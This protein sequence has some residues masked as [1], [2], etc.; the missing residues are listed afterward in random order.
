MPHRTVFQVGKNHVHPFTMFV[1]GFL[2]GLLVTGAVCWAWAMAED[3]DVESENVLVPKKKSTP[4]PSP[5]VVPT[6][7]PGVSF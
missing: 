6:A 1:G 7:S 5:S 4:S 2:V 3:S